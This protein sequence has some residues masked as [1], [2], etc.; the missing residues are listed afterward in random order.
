MSR[1]VALIDGNS[2]YCSC[3]RV[4]DPKLK[5]VPVVVL[6]EQRRLRDR[7][8]NAEA[9]AL[10]IRMGEPFFKIRGLC[11]SGG[12][13]VFSS[14]Y[15]L[16]GDMSSRMNTIYRQFSARRRDLLDRREL[17]RP[18]RR[19]SSRSRAARSRP[20]GDGAR[21]DGGADLCRDRADEDAGQAR[22]PHCEA[23][24]R[25][26]RRLRPVRRDHPRDVAGGHQAGGGLGHRA[27]V[28]AETARTRVR[29]GRGRRSAR[30]PT[31]P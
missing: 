31:S 8:H 10:G 26:G 13:R 22:Q 27:G 3:E 9:K 20:A 30:S 23:R 5:G 4:F 29:Y 6:V 1:A 25:N 28:G 24:T 15:A 19:A 14:N 21:V 16:Y 18:H 12:V 11:R 7:P 2:F 17:P